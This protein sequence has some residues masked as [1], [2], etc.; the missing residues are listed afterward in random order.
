MA[1]RKITRELKD[2]TNDP[3]EYCSVGPIG[4]DM[5][6]WNATIMG[7][8]ETPYEDGVF[9]LNVIF[10]YDYPFKPPRVTFYDQN[11]PS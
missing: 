7:P 2:I 8:P 4:D 9:F 1:L 3:P 6:R 5:F 11:L 10:P